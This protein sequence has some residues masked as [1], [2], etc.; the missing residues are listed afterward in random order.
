MTGNEFS[1]RN[2]S[3]NQKP[4]QQQ[5]KEAAPTYTDPMAREEIEWYL[6]DT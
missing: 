6:Q 1:Q 4:A 5:P 2:W 3:I